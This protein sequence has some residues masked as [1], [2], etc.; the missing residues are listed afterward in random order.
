MFFEVEMAV[1]VGEMTV[2]VFVA[3]FAVEGDGG[4]R[5]VNLDAISALG[6][7]VLFQER[8]NFSAD[9]LALMFGRNEDRRNPTLCQTIPIWRNATTTDDF[10]ILFD[11]VKMSVFGFVFYLIV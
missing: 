2:F 5:R 9:T 1:V 3:E 6:I 10:V 8:D 4:N 7:F 11:N